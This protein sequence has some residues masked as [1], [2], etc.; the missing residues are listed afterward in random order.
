MS[1]GTAICIAIIGV[2]T[3]G[4]TIALLQLNKAFRHQ[5]Q[6]FKSLNQSVN[7]L[8]RAFE[9]LEERDRPTN[10]N[11]TV[12]DADEFVRRVNEQVERTERLRDL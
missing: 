5:N 10:Y 3:L 11:L 7:N 2:A 1:L 12:S 4:N 9:L 8:S 6:A